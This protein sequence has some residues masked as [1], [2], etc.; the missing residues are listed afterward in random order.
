MQ[1]GDRETLHDYL[2]QLP[3]ERRGELVD[4]VVTAS[5]AVQMAVGCLTEPGQRPVTLVQFR[6]YLDRGIQHLQTARDS[7]PA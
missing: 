7:L 5:L 1:E 3:A 4:D 6:S 2:A